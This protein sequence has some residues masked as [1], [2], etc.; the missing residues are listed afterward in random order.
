V[1]RN[2]LCLRACFA[3]AQE[4][5]GSSVQTQS[6]HMREQVSHA[7][8]T[9]LLLAARACLFN[10]AINYRMCYGGERACVI[11]YYRPHVPDLRLVSQLAHFRSPFPTSWTTFSSSTLRRLT[12]FFLTFILPDCAEVSTIRTLQHAQ[13]KQTKGRTPGV[14]VPRTSTTRAGLHQLSRLAPT[15][16]PF[17]LLYPCGSR[18]SNLSCPCASIALLRLCGSRMH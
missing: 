16:A 12:P 11:I 8:W 18:R 5:G 9:W 10:A 7:P 17:A 14:E 4:N 3:C 15:C 2:S 6:H 1:Q 13:H